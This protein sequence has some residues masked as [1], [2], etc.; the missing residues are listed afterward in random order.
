[1]QNNIK[2]ITT[3][4]GIQIVFNDGE[5]SLH[6]EDP[7]G[8]TWDMDGKGNIAVN[9]PNK[10]MLNAKD[11]DINANENIT[12]ISGKNTNQSVGENHILS[13]SGTS[14]ISIE[15]TLD[16]IVTENMSLNI[17]KDLEEIISG[18]IS[19]NAKKIEVISDGI[20][21]MA[22]QD[23]MTLKSASDVIIAQ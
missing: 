9:A 8:N 14:N 23:D 17:E 21:K 15:K 6:I 4:S 3:K 1:M 11:I 5:K 16:V 7:S 2:S 10:I 12:L 22:A 19:Q 18:N 13:V 20:L